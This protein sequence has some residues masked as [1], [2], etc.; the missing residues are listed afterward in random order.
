MTAGD[1]DSSNQDSKDK[2]PKEGSM[3]TQS[4]ISSLQRPS[5]FLG[6]AFK[7]MAMTRTPCKGGRPRETDAP[8]TPLPLA[9]PLCL[10]AGTPPLALPEADRPVPSNGAPPASSPS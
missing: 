8:G 2:D 1:Q 7:S 6:R 4:S 3:T 5:E 10:A 9:T